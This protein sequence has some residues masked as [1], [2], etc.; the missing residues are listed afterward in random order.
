MRLD[1]AEPLKFVCI[2][3]HPFL[4]KHR[5]A[6]NGLSPGLLLGAGRSRSHAGHGPDPRE[7]L[8]LRCS[9]LAVGRLIVTSW[10]GWMEC[11]A[12]RHFL[13]ERVLQ[14]W[15]EQGTTSLRRQDCCQASTLLLG[16]AF[17]V[18][19]LAAIMKVH[20]FHRGYQFL[21]SETAR[22]CQFP[23]GR[24]SSPFGALEQAAKLYC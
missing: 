1:A 9:K 7:P 18:R 13:K 23:T 6:L 14:V 10:A 4:S 16:L 17:T 3:Q 15:L 8:E 19:I 2:M 22:Y 12:S 5:I 24:T 21:T 11:D 20:I